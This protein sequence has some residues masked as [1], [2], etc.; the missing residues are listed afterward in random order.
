MKNGKKLGKFCP[1][2]DQK[3]TIPTEIFLDAFLLVL[4]KFQFVSSKSFGPH[5]FLSYLKE[6]ELQVVAKH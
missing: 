5:K 3:F 6:G 2:L 1:D 4:T